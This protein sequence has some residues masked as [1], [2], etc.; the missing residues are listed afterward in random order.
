MLIQVTAMLLIFLSEAETYCVV[1]T[2]LEDSVKLLDERDSS[3]AQE[4][5]NVRWHFTTRKEDFEK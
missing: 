2:M 5:R 3:K 4:M 1:L